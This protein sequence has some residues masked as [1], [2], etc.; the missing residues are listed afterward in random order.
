MIKFCKNSLVGMCSIL[1]LSA[2]AIESVDLVNPLQGTDSS[3]EISTG[4]TYPAVAVP[5]GTNFW[6]PQT[7]VNGNGWQY[8]YNDSI[9]RGF[10]QTH[11]PSPWIN[12]Y[13]C[14]SVFPTNNKKVFASKQRGLAFKHENEVARPYYYSV[15]FHKEKI[16]TELTATNSGSV[17]RLHYADREN[18]YL[19]I[20]G[21][22]G[23][24]K[25]DLDVKNGKLTGYS[26]WYAPNNKANLPANFATHFVIAFDQE[27][28]EY[29]VF[30]KNAPVPN[31][32]SIKGVNVGMYV[33]LKLTPANQA[34]VRIGSSFIGL[35]QAKVNL[36]REINNAG[37]DELTA[38][39][40]KAW[41]VLM[42]KIQVEGGTLEERKTFYT[43]LYRTL[44]F[45]RRLHET[46]ADGKIK[47]YSPLNG[48]IEDGF[49]YTDNGF[50]DTFRAVHPFFTMV[51]PSISSEIISS[52]NNYYKEGGWFP[53]WC[54]PGYKDCMIG[55]N[56]VSLVA[57]AYIKGIR[58]FDAEMAFEAMVK[59]ANN[60]GPIEA[61]GRDGVKWYNKM[62]YIPYNVGKTESVSKT[63]EYAYN[64]Y[65]I[66]IMAKA[67]G[68]PQ[69]VVDLYA[70]RAMNY[71]N[72][73]DSNIN[74]VRPKDDKGKWLTP[75]RPDAWGGSFTEG[76][77]W[78][79]S[80]TV[81]HDPAGLI[82][83]MGGKKRFIERMDSLFVAE[84]T[85]DYTNYKKVIH[86]MTEMVLCEMGQYAHGNQPI[87][88]AI[89]LYNYAGQPYKTQ[90]RVREV[91]SKLYDSSESGLCGDED[92][93]Q[94]SAWYVFSALGF[95]PVCPGSREYV[96]GS[97]LFDKATIHLENGNQFTVITQNNSPENI[98]IQ[99]AKLNGKKFN[100][101]FITHQEIMD[102]G[103]LEFIMSNKP[104]YK[105]AAN[106]SPFSMSNGKKN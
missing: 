1:I 24:G 28:L 34:L 93:G 102:G 68:K 73:F 11:Q 104:N 99:S 8:V 55:Q 62:G 42:D 18:A 44:L 86:E 52:L 54:S 22:H 38:K 4:N 65:C 82:Q 53:E 57:D 37:F 66:S 26:K 29:G 59:G 17:F 12:D 16:K 80:F 83:L 31:Q 32:T 3:F 74:F 97:P 95:Y 67:L 56:S 50:W 105:W 76:S 21:F 88:H 27:I 47:H 46:T 19:I 48:K 39:N 72:V 85:F 51:Y 2:N 14:F 63:L 10:K 92:N 96:I 75:F 15:L 45:P 7:G 69:E 25:L 41:T 84:P 91:M 30:N 71:K 87:Q 23:E 58:G 6:T 98:Y 61:V 40:K 49:Y 79:W 100:N 9:I 89:Y 103:E 33:R 77:S 94:T 64:D 35:E 36:K 101:S 90:Q 20:D 81:M 60:E 106:S 78:H 70:K 43:A 5:W 13:G